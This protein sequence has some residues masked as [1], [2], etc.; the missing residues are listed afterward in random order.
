MRLLSTGAGTIGK[1]KKEN[2]GW[3]PTTSWTS[4]YQTAPLHH[5]TTITVALERWRKRL[6]NPCTIVATFSSSSNHTVCPLYFWDL[7]MVIGLYLYCAFSVA[8]HSKRFYTTCHINPFTHTAHLS[9]VSQA[10]GC[11]VLYYT[12]S[13]TMDATWSYSV[14]LTCGREAES[15][16]NKSPIGRQLHFLLCYSC[17]LFDLILDFWETFPAMDSPHMSDTFLFTVIMSCHAGAADRAFQRPTKERPKDFKRKHH[18][19]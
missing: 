1:K 3:F 5:Y 7:E 16:T 19:Y 18:G 12:Y 13:D 14:S 17:H 8:D 11:F 15:R 2:W 4:I 9:L 10:T 6:Q